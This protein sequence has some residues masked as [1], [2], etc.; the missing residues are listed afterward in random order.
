MSRSFTKSTANY[1]SLGVAALGPRLNGTKQLS[2]SVWAWLRSLDTG[3]G[4]NAILGVLF[5]SNTAAIDFCIDAGTACGIRVRSQQTD[6]AGTRSSSTVITTGRW[7]HLGATVDFTSPSL[8]PYVN[9]VADNTPGVPTFGSATY[10][11]SAGTNPDMIGHVANTNYPPAV[12]GLQINGFLADLA[13]WRGKVR[14]DEWAR[15]GRGAPPGSIRPDVL[16]GWWPMA[17]SGIL[18][19]DYGPYARHAKVSGGSI[20]LGPDPPR[21][22]RVVRSPVRRHPFVHVAVEFTGSV[23]ANLGISPSATKGVERTRSLT[24]GLGL[25]PSTSKVVDWGKSVSVGLGLSP[26]TTKNIDKV[27]TLTVGLGLHPLAAQN[28]DVT[29]AVS[30]GL[31]LQPSTSRSVD[32]NRSVSTGLGL[33]P[34]VSRVADFAPNVTTGLGLGVVATPAYFRAFQTYSFS[35]SSSFGLADA[36]AGQRGQDQ[37][38]LGRFRLGDVVEMSFTPEAMPAGGR[39]EAVVRD[40]A[41]RLVATLPLWTWDDVTWQASLFLGQQIPMGTLTTE[42][43]SVSLSGVTSTRW[44]QFEVVAGGDPAGGVIALHAHD[45]PSGRLVLVQLA[46]G[47]LL[48]GNDP[49]MGDRA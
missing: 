15:L 37:P 22:G 18:M 35:V 7:W 9:G 31:G 34:S 44:A 3:A 17:S 36:A 33:Q 14:P 46:S 48:Q 43:T 20:P 13:I 6:A 39:P 45:G 12:T 41:G 10:V 5:S 40:T 47:S 23:T 1:A 42:W 2:I 16:V 4:S 21:P 11:H 32:R 19:R 30:A 8:Q 24:V 27:I 26:S 25:S 38:A 49:N 28:I 29:I